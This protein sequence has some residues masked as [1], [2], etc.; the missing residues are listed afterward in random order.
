[1]KDYVLYHKE[2]CFIDPQE[3]IDEPDWLMVF[4]CTL[5]GKANAIE[6]RKTVEDGAD[7]AIAYFFDIVE[8]EKYCELLTIETKQEE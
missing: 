4:P 6:V 5:Q 2:R 8:A 1:M 3:I 7:V